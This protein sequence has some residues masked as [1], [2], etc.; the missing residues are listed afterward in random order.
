MLGYEIKKA[1]CFVCNINRTENGVDS[2]QIQLNFNIAF[3]IK[4]RGTVVHVIRPL[5]Y[6]TFGN[7]TVPENTTVSCEIQNPV[8][9]SR[10]LDNGQVEVI[11]NAPVQLESIGTQSIVVPFVANCPVGL[12]PAVP[13]VSP[14]AAEN[15]KHDS[16]NGGSEETA[17]G[18]GKD[19]A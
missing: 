17:S 19:K 10:Q 3:F 16:S 11:I 14:D 13:T 2:V 6:I 8:C 1:E 5:N 4:S 18:S 9:N 12:C 15:G 7:L